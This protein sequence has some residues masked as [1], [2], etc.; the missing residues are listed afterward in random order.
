MARH[1]PSIRDGRWDYRAADHG[2][3]QVRILGLVDDAVVQPKQRRNR[4]ERQPRG[5]HQSIV[6]PIVAAVAERAD[7]GQ[8]SKQL[9][10]H[11]GEE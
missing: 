11:L 2:G 3:H 9:R 4:P 1:E 6:H 8:H 7:R 10:A 5:H